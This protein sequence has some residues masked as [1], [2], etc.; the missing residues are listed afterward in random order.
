MVAQIR[1]PRTFRSEGNSRNRKKSVYI[2]SVCVSVDRHMALGVIVHVDEFVLEAVVVGQ[3]RSNRLQFRRCL[4]PVITKLPQSPKR[5]TYSFA[6][7]SEPSKKVTTN[8]P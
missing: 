2:L 7:L 1:G 6:A 8:R 4:R 5:L 3:R